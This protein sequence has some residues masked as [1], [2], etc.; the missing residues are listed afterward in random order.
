MEAWFR[1][2]DTL[3]SSM[4]AVLTSLPSGIRRD[5]MIRGATAYLCA[6]RVE[7]IQTCT[8]NDIHYCQFY[9][10]F[11]EFGEQA[12]QTEYE[13]KIPC[14]S[15]CTFASQIVAERIEDAINEE[16]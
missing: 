14:A 7:A 13:M 11:L 8:G 12:M 3:R 2:Q 15:G 4:K 1:G 9:K 16:G 6:A 5:K 10:D